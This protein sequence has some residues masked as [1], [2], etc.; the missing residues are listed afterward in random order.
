MENYAVI[1]YPLGHSLSP[2]LHRRLWE[3]AP[4]GECSYEI[5]E[6]PPNKL[7]FKITKKRLLKLRGFNVT[8]PLKTGIIPLLDGLDDAASK[9]GSVN[10]V[11][12]RDGKL[13]GYNTDIF[14]LT[15]ALAKY[16]MPI[17]KKV[18]VYGCG[19][20]ARS[21][22]AAVIKAGGELTVAARDI[23][24]A[25]I[26][27]DS[28][29]DFRKDAKIEV[30]PID[31]IG[32]YETVINC[33]PAGMFKADN[34][35][36]VLDCAVPDEVIKNCSNIYDLVY[37]PKLTELV[38]RGRAAGKNAE[39]GMSM[40][41]Y[42]AIFAQQIWRDDFMFSEIMSTSGIANALIDEFSAKFN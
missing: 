6:L 26:F 16:K 17:N 39:S 23:K 22:A 15:L 1:G 21:A 29:R 41:V 7:K 9:I 38:K 35:K 12:K 19:G 24:K 34:E 5:L 33:T 32:E 37:N 10:T 14:G 18:L 2:E 30:L 25:E 28:F 42:Q 3:I 31:H 40:L 20:S 11:S 27:K 4:C 36:A 13:F 8:I